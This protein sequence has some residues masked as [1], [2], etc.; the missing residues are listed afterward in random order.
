MSWRE[1]AACRGL[2]IELFF[3]EDTGS[4][5]KYTNGIEVCNKCTVKDECLI[6]ALST[7]IS[8]NMFG[9]RGGLTPR[10]RQ[11]NRANLRQQYG[12]TGRVDS[13]QF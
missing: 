10:Y 8:T 13:G 12:L 2:D 4:H 6:D 11:I 9:L 7:E 5:Y 3:P 1:S